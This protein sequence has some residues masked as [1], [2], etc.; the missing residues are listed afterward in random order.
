MKGVQKAP[1]PKGGWIFA[2]GKKT[3]GFYAALRHI[4]LWAIIPPTSSASPPRL[5]LLGY[6][7]L[8]KGGLAQLRLVISANRLRMATSASTGSVRG[9]VTVSMGQ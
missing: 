5:R 8:G 4:A 1:L 9:N 7:P 6:L 2:V 3:G